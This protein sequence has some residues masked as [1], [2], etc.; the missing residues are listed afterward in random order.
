[1]VVDVA[2][3]SAALTNCL[4]PS[5]AFLMNFLVRIWTGSLSDMMR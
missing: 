4:L 5:S 1:M 2:D 3:F